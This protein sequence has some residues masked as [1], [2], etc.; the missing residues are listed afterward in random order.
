MWKEA[1]RIEEVSSAI[2]NWEDAFS[3]AER[4]PRQVYEVGVCFFD[5]ASDHCAFVENYYDICG[6]CP[7]H[8]WKILRWAKLIVLKVAKS[9]YVFPM[10]LAILPLVTGLVFGVL[11]GRSWNRLRT[12]SRK[13]WIF[14]GVWDFFGR[15]LLWIVLLWCQPTHCRSKEEASSE[16]SRGDRP[17]DHHRAKKTHGLA[18]VS[19]HDNIDTNIHCHLADTIIAPSSLL[20]REKHARVC[21]Q[22]VGLG[23]ERESGVPIELIPAHIAIIMDGNRRYGRENFGDETRGHWEGSRKLLELAKWCQAEH[24]KVL[25]VYAFST[26]NWH[27]DPVEVA[28][29]MSI[30][31][32]YAEELRQSA[33]ERNIQVRVLSTDRSFIPANV[34]ARLERLEQD[35]RQCSGGLVV[36]VCLSYGS[37]GEIVGACRDI[38]SACARGEISVDAITESLFGDFLLT[39][40]V[41]DP[42]ILIRTSGEYRISNFLLWQLAY[43]ELFFLEKKWPEIQKEDILDILRTYALGRTRRF[44]K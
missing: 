41:P 36:N 34:R 3:Y 38:A 15:G 14:H 40:K 32:R 18:V 7:D 37:R 28:S 26:E 2:L 17:K 13:D 29:L 33:L 25:T 42:D 23:S 43:S 11:I 19:L 44:G 16:P 20:E 9:Y 21:L 4:R 6:Y 27:R 31:L 8:A 10:V 30:L 39:R 24:I 35:T 22:Q 1:A 12:R 5:N